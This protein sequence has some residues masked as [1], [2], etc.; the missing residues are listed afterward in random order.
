MA[1]GKSDG[2]TSHKVAISAHR[3]GKEDAA[4]DSWEAYEASIKSGAE[5]VEFDVRSTADEFV[6]FHDE[7]VG[8]NRKPIATLSHAE[9]C[10]EVGYNVPSVPEVMKLIAGKAIGHVDIKDIGN[11]KEIISLAL[12]TLGAGGFVATSLEDVSILAIKKYAPEVR[13]ALSLGRNLRGFPARLKV[14]TRAS[15][16]FPLDRIRACRADWVAVDQRLARYR[17]LEVCRRHEIGAMV[18]T[19]NDDL[20]IKRFLDDSRVTVLITDRPR[21]AVGVR[22]DSTSGR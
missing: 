16:L 22:D 2:P 9:L 14:R 5:Y 7:H 18:W 10:D 19:V 21:F 20:M 17:V 11:E 12:D 6:C 1:V 4:S 13:T 3:G 8:P 15:E